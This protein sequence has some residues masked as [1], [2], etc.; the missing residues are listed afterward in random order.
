MIERLL[1]LLQPLMPEEVRQWSRVLESADP[2][3]R[4]L[5]E[6]HVA[7][8]ARRA[9]GDHERKIL[10][11]LPPEHQIKGPIQLGTIVYERDK[12]TAGIHEVELLQHLAVFGRS[13][14][15][16]TNVVFHLIEQLDARG[17]PFLFLDWKR[18]CRHLLPR[19]RRSVRVY[20]PGRSLAPLPFNPFTP[21]T[22]I[23]PSVYLHQVVD[24]LGDALTLG[25]G[26]RS[27]LHRILA[28]SYEKGELSP[29]TLGLI[30]QLDA[31]P[32]TGRASGW[33]ISARRALES[34]S[35]AGMTGGTPA[36]QR[37]FAESLLSQS[38]I[39]ELDSLGQ[40][41]R[42]FLI[43]ILCLWIYQ[44]KLAA[45]RREKLDLVVVLE[46]AHHVLFRQER[47]GKET[48]LNGLLRQ[49]R[50]MGVGVIV[51]DQHPALISSAG[52]GNVFASVCM[53]LRDPPDLATAAALSGIEASERELFGRLPLGHGVV[54]FQGRWRRPFVVRFPLIPV[55]KG[56]VTDT[57]LARYLTEQTTGSAPRPLEPAENGQVRLS[58]SPEASLRSAELLF[59]RD[60]LARPDDGVKAR[61]RRLGWSVHRGNRTKLFLLKMGWLEAQ[62][63]PIG[64]TRKTLLR[65]TKLAGQALGA[66]VGDSID[67]A[68]L[69]HQYWQR[70]YARMLR[71]RGYEVELEAPRH[72][73][74]VDVLATSGEER[75]GIE[76]ETGLSDAAENVRNGLREGFAHL[77][78]VVTERHALAQVERALGEA[79]LLIGG[80]V[81]LLLAPEFA[82][83]PEPSGR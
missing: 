23:E 80:R 2:A 79:G 10:L 13:G 43:P 47:R 17:V 49:F 56:A 33:K 28:A 41:I 4:G 21:P 24:V 76:I 42:R 60:V 16:K 45:S 53:N 5:L 31:V 57:H 40:G 51:V 14:A 74:R 81:R 62:R 18:T 83:S 65:L 68:T 30:E 6:G 25:D 54:K 19:L 22:G 55:A 3:T 50:E 26:A 8:V 61:Y 71:E 27:L 7:A 11:S 69:A 78:V 48:L 38:T 59:L 70:W 82:P 58:P 36:A 77:W 37:T 44:T 52:R 12:W 34:L 29:T 9:L 1:C 46:E 15:G 39:I 67:G 35:L 32:T 66:P 64:R 63:I 75:I 20:T 73:G 72:G